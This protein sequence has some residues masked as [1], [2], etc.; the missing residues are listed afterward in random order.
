[1]GKYISEGLRQRNETIIRNGCYFVCKQFEKTSQ[2]IFKTLVGITK[3]MFGR[4][5]NAE[6]PV[7]KWLSAQDR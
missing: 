3:Q 1:M 2:T 5:R 6:T 4:K 7:S